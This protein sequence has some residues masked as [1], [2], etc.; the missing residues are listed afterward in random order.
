MSR[1]ESE[2]TFAALPPARG[3]GFARTWWGQAWLKALEDTALDGE[4]L[5]RGRK[6]ARE[7]AVGAVCVR[8]GRVTAV[9]RDR[10]RTPYRSDVLLREFTDAEWDRLLGWSRTAPAISPPCWTAT[11]LRSWPRTRRPWASNCCRG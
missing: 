7:G 3:R 2:R 1:T 10:D 5:K 9:V 4:Q 8:P 11:C 6:Q